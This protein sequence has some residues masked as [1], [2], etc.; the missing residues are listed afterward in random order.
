MSKT[1]AKY[2][3]EFKK[4]VCKLVDEGKRIC[5]VAEVY[6]ISAPIIRYWLQKYSVNPKYHKKA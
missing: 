1:Y 4:H 5:V 6:G 3:E 2:D